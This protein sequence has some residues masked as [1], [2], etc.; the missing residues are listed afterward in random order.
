MPESAI[1]DT[2]IRQ[3]A[4]IDRGPGYFEPR[5]VKL[6]V[7]VEDYYEVLQGLPGSGW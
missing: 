7:K 4:I 1:I 6:G 5:D 2:G 3:V